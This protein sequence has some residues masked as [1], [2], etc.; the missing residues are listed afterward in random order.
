MGPVPAERVIIVGQGGT[1]P[2]GNSLLPYAQV[3]RAS[4]LLLRVQSSNLLF[5][6]PYSEHASK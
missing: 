5:D 1:Y 2:H 4:H 6:H 3:H